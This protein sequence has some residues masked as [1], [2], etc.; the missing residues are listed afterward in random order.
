VVDFKGPAIDKLPAE[1]PL[2][3][4]VAPADPSLAEVKDV[5]VHRNP[6]NGTWRLSFYVRAAGVDLPKPP[7]ADEYPKL[8]PPQFKAPVEL[9]AFLKNGEDVLSETWNYRLDP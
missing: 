4:V 1:T 7:A 8:K 9:R 2:T 5:T 6:V 3:A